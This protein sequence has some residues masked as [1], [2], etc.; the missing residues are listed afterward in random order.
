M[1]RYSWP[2]IGLRPRLLLATL[3]PVLVVLGGMVYAIASF[4]DVL[5]HDLSH[6]QLARDL[7]RAITLYQRD[8]ALLAVLQPEVRTFVVPRGD[9]AGLPPP[10]RH[11]ASGESHEVKL[12]D[13]EYEYEAT[14]R[15]I[16]A[17][18]LYVL[19]DLTPNERLEKELI[20]VAWLAGLGALFLAVIV[21]L[22]LSHVVMQPVRR[23]AARLSQVRPG[24]RRPQL[25]PAMGERYLNVIARA[26]DDMLDRFD[27][28]VAR[29]QAFT[30]DA[31]HE[32]R[33]PLATV[34]SSLDLIG[35][36][37]TLSWK[38]RTRLMRA[39]GAAMRMH[40]LIETLL[41][42]AREQESQRA[43]SAVSPV[44]REAIAM[45][46]QLIVDQDE[47]PQIVFDVQTEAWVAAPSSMVLSVANNLLRNAVEHGGSMRI[48]VGLDA[49]CLSIRDHGSG[50]TPAI[51]SRLFDRR[52]R[53]E[54][55]HGQGL[56]LYLVKRISERFDWRLEVHSTP[57]E[58]TCFLVYFTN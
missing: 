7:E 47:R 44:V 21:A 46:E 26:F 27:A 33:T 18:S 10:L 40:E 32:L 12:A 20:G 51:Q 41:L 4:L 49:H 57:G 17:H 28:F 37:A 16:G 29:E 35:E 5:E 19:L 25:A 39:R 42:F 14:R 2:G 11:L 56:G 24:A 55:S 58:G 30:E 45:Q 1:M 8:P 9:T 31:S 50:M 22:W 53:G 13:A 23:L 6:D 52:F 36:D 54:H 43:E 3:V 38:S 34:I 48:D 15:D